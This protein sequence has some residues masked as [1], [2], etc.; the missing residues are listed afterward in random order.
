MPTAKP[1]QTIVHRIEL[2]KTERAFLE[3]Y[4]KSRRETAVISALGQASGPILM[5]VGVAATGWLAVQ[6]W[7]QINDAL[8]GPIEDAKEILEAA[9]SPLS[10]YLIARLDRQIAARLTESELQATDWTE[11]TKTRYREDTAKLEKRKAE[12]FPKEDFQ[13]ILPSWLDWIVEGAP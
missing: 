2:Q 7:I 9:K 12:G 10:S 13:Q 3:E 11:A 4:V 5:A 1:T 8:S 6:A